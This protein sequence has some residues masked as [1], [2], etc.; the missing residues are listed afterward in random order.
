MSKNEW[1][2]ILFELLIANSI[3]WLF[4]WDIDTKTKIILPNVIILVMVGLTF[5]LKLMGV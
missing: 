1:G 4:G 3:T 2:F 5:S